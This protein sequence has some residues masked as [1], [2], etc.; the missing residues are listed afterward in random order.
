M[1]DDNHREIISLHQLVVKLA[2]ELDY[3]N[4]LLMEK[5]GLSLERFATMSSLIEEKDRLLG[6]RS[7]VIGSLMAQKH[8][9]HEG[10]V[11]EMR[12]SEQLKQEIKNIR[13][14]LEVQRQKLDAR[15]MEQEELLTK[16]TNANGYSESPE[17]NLIVPANQ[18]SQSFD[19]HNK[20]QNTLEML[21]HL[22]SRNEDLNDQLEILR[23]ELVE[24]GEAFH[25]L[26]SLNQTLISNESSCNEELKS[27][28][29]EAINF[30]LNIG[31]DGTKVGIKRIGEID[32]Q[33]FRDE[34]ADENDKK[35][36]ELRKEWGEEAYKAVVNA[37]LDFRKYN[38][39]MKS[40]IPELW[41]FE[42]GRRA[43]MKE[44]IQYIIKRCEFYRNRDN[45]QSGTIFGL[46]A[47]KE[48]L[49]RKLAGINILME[50]KD[51]LLKEKCA[52]IGKSIEQDME[53]DKTLNKM[54]A[55][56]STLTAEKHMLLESCN[57][58]QRNAWR[59]RV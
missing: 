19:K 23:R 17:I 58:E 54:S 52:E 59:S 13:H 53:K 49:L 43:Y 21:Q 9:L 47:E 46:M 33:P 48:R 30:F 57:A 11:E 55:T 40:S 36:A 8:R 27:A 24:K 20:L 31:G 25:Q 15:T 51:K 35:L 22:R 5:E 32:P 45:E 37:L 41:N 18:L 38:L 16:S 28:R 42:E 29:M 2:K 3:K 7:A 56:I 34:V 4:H 44:V 6:E 14:R 50:E 12:K 26:E 1:A 39:K 10:F